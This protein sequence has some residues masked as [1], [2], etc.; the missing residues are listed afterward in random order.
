MKSLVRSLGRF[1]ARAFLPFACAFFASSIADRAMQSHFELQRR[2]AVLE[3]DA[4][5]PRPIVEVELESRVVELPEDGD[6]WFTVLIVRPDYKTLPAERRAVAA[7]SSDP[8]LASLKAQTHFELIETDKP[9]FEK[10][11]SCVD[12]TPCLILERPNGQV[13]YRE[14]GP[15]LGKNSRGLVKAIEKQIERHC[16]DGRCLP[17]HPTPVNDQPEQGDE[18]PTITIPGDPPKARSLIPVIAIAGVAALAGFARKFR[19]AA[20]V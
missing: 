15:Q 13:I 5:S 2:V 10:F 20:Q 12:V 6:Q 3:E 16:P 1:V 8:A 14:S 17:L 7:F 18:P 9:A 19:L 4:F 11:A